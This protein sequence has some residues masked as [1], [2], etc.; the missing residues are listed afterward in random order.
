MKDEQREQIEPVGWGLLPDDYADL[1]EDGQRLARIHA[2]S[3][4]SNADEFVA[5]WALF[6]SLYLFPLPHGSFYPHGRHPSPQAHYEWVHD[7]YA[8]PRNAIGAP[9]AAAKSIVLGKEIPLMRAITRPYHKIAIGLSSDKFVE[10]RLDELSQQFKR[11]E[12]IINDFGR[13]HPKKGDKIWNLHQLS[14]LNGSVIKGVSVESRKLGLRP[15]DIFLDDPEYNPDVEGAETQLLKDLEKLIFNEMFP[16][17]E[18]DGRFIWIG[19]LLSRRAA[20]WNVLMGDDPRFDY[21]NRRIYS[22]VKYNDHGKTTYF[23]RAKWGP[24]EVAKRRRE[25]GIAAF[26]AQCQNNPVSKADRILRIDDPYNLY[27][28]VGD[29]VRWKVK[30]ASGVPEGF[31]KDYNEWLK[32]LG[33]LFLV[34]PAAKPEVSNDFSCCLAVGI[35]K[36]KVWWVLDMFQGRMSHTALLSKIYEFGCLW[37]PIVVGVESIGFQDIVRQDTEAALEEETAGKAWQPR[38]WPI[39]YRSKLSK[40]ARIE[41]I[42]SRFSRHMVRFPS[43]LRETTCK[44]L[45]QQVEDFTPDLSLLPH[46][47]AV[48]CLAMVPYCPRVS[49]SGIVKRTRD[50]SIEGQILA[51]RTT[52]I[53]TG[54]PLI[55]FINTATLDPLIIDKVRQEKHWRRTKDKQQKL[56]SSAQEKMRRRT[57]SSST[58]PLERRRIDRRK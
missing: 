17:L 28:V 36:D 2:V 19:T 48:D 47:D 18:D 56:K 55:L 34:D 38:V 8:H 40:P 6:R 35:D 12:Y 49:P 7:Y 1:T 14:L 16:M 43:H 11:N 50:N 32:T 22:M 39:Q 53:E 46:D 29:R 51:G 3:T 41:A 21:W 37:K 58:S 30:G 10:E 26:E 27:E 45:F 57:E 9:R 42:C 54:L 20:L 13:I 24:K 5:A 33:C 52:E 25:Y 44:P 4:Y 23:W 15:H 31:D